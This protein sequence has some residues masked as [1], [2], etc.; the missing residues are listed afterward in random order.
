VALMA[1]V[2]ITA[3]LLRPPRKPDLPDPGF[4]G[5]PASAWVHNFMLDES[6]EAQEAL[7]KIGEPAVPFLIPSLRQKNSWFN[8]V[9]VRVWPYFPTMLKSRLAQPILS[10]DVR[11]RAVVALREMGPKAKPAVAAL[12]ER[13][14][15]KDKTV[16]LHSA[17][18]LGNIGPDA[19][20]AVPALKPFLKERHT[21]RVYTANALWK[22]EHNAQEVLPV[23]EQG[24][25]E[26]N[27]PFRWAAAVFLGEMGP[28][29]EPAIP[30]LIQATRAADKETASCAVQSLA[31]ISPT[32]IPALIETLSDADPGMRI[33][34]ALAL[35]NLG[36]TAKQ[37][38]PAL[39]RLLNEAA[40][41]EPTIMGRGM[42]KESVSNAAANA[43]MKIDA[44]AAAGL[45][46]K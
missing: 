25:R 11:M 35:G 21:V 1:T 19:R 42:G 28:A 10:T 32:T 30:A 34:A 8:A 33:S 16:R 44:G 23:L 5:K 36:P 2:G 40:M 27:A 31:Q 29:A 45:S 43:I 41:G 38:I 7:R 37:S 17:I 26:E 3:V 12:I 14:G 18:A 9:Y 15:D 13:L 6:F 4:N 39:T 46:P 20:A 22:I 24:V